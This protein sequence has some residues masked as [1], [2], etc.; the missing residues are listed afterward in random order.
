MCRRRSSKKVHHWLALSN[1]AGRLALPFADAVGRL[2][3]ILAVHLREAKL[4]CPQQAA[5]ATRPNSLS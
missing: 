5:Q 1:A 3:N 2:T 4:A